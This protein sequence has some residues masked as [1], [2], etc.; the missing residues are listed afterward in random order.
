MDNGWVPVSAYYGMDESPI[1]VQA[2]LGSP[3]TTAAYHPDSTIQG[4]LTA[5]YTGYYSSSQVYHIN[6]S[7]YNFPNPFC[8]ACIFIIYKFYIYEICILPKEIKYSSHKT[9]KCLKT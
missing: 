9:T 2:A 7:Y 3:F 6:D 4:S 5:Q 1:P 8:Q